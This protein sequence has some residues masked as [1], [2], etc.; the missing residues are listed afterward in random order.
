MTIV[1]LAG[2]VVAVVVLLF[3]AVLAVGIPPGIMTSAI[4]ARVERDTGFRIEFGGATRIA[5]WPAFRL[6]LNDVT[7]ERHGGTEAAER[8]EL[9]TTRVE[10]PL[11][12]LWS[13]SL[14][15]TE[16]A[17]ERPAIY[18]PLR[19][20]RATK[21]AAPAGGTAS[22]DQTTTMPRIDR[23]TVTDGAVIFANRRDKVEDRIEAINL[24]ATVGNRQMTLTGGARSGERTFKLDLRA[25][26]PDD[27]SARR[28]ATVDLAF[29]APGLV[30]GGLTAKADVRVAGAAVRING[31]SGTLDG[32]PFTG[33]ASVDLAD[34]PLVKLD[35]DIQEIA[36]GKPA[37]AANAPAVA[38]QPAAE[39]NNAPFDLRGL[40][41]VDAE[42]RV[43]A[44]RLA[45]GDFRI[46]PLALGATLD[47]GV[48][49][50]RIENS[51]LYDGLAN[52]TLTLDA[53]GPA[54]RFDAQGD[55][56]GV[57]ALPLLSGLADF[58]RLDGKLQ[59]T[60][61][62]Q[63]SGDSARAVMANLAGT[64]S[65]DFRDGAIRGINVAQMIRSLTGRTL[66]GWQ[67]DEVQATD[68]SQLSASFR[69]A[70][71]RA[72]TADLML[73]GPLV[74]MTGAGTVDLGGK[75]LALRVEP[76]LVMT[77][78]GQ[79]GK[80]DP[81]GLGVPVMI[82]GPW[83][84]PRIYP[85]VA[86]I[87]DNPAAAYGRLR[88]LGQGL[89]GISP[90]NGTGENSGDNNSLGETLGGMI[91]Q[92]LGARPRPDAAPTQSDPPG[93]TDG[94]SPVDGILKQ[95]FGR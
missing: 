50:A 53:S 35:L 10:M 72:E 43:S 21:A 81:V 12:N 71:G 19:R 25:A 49:T 69:I 68:L 32:K 60:F 11:A 33:W 78:E 89:F 73:A 67:A 31:L 5:L 77:L 76:R 87:L 48:L 84:A 6:T 26:L 58:D 28:A 93:R 94:G 52:G 4:G 2:A 18:L 88:E 61:A 51:G 22:G 17:L 80:T 54:P 15:I 64:A 45:S 57:R 63:S 82:A 36:L 91:R 24:A 92:G 16:L 14:A 20:E 70:Q 1:K 30:A 79:G 85:D 37:P 62:V 74:R 90:D 65:L 7:L 38:P 39:W 23:V 8:V 83:A 75:A 42:V 47:R 46:A 66:N 44:A 95:L 86:G 59:A 41:Y 34:K 13:G 40:N 3:A 29:E 9:A 56:A 27:A 55:L